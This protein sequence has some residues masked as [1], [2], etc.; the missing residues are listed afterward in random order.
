MSDETESTPLRLLATTHERVRRLFEQARDP[1][2]AKEALE[3]AASEACAAWTRLAQLEDELFYPPLKALGVGER[4]LHEGLIEH[5]LA[6]Q[7]V[8]RLGGT[9]PADP[10]Y[11]AVLAVLGDCVARHL[12]KTEK[13]LFPLASAVDLGALAE[14]LRAG[15][16][17]A[18]GAEAESENRTPD[19]RLDV[20]TGEDRAPPLPK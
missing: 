19:G 2:L 5:Q 20:G 10:A 14:R 8:K 9:P 16:E 7:L 3:P 13:S 18:P 17:P 6:A 12:E 4:Q 1:E 11:R 15:P